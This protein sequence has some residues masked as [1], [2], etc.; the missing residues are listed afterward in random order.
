MPFHGINTERKKHTNAI[1]P[2]S[3]SHPPVLLLHLGARFLLS[4]LASF[5]GRSK[6]RFV[7]ESRMVRI[8]V[9]ETG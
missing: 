3:A 4:I 6:E 1:R 9:S 5:N 2:V 7:R 8:D